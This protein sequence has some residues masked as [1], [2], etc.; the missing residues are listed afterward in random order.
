[1]GGRTGS[2]PSPVPYIFLP[3]LLSLLI[4]VPWGAPRCV[5]GCAPAVPPCPG[6]EGSVPNPKNERC[7]PWGTSLG[8]LL[9]LW[10]ALPIKRGAGR[11]GQAPGQPRGKRG[12]E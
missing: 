4:A 5:W 11:L 12:G 3:L 8:E 9:S 10:G 6:S 2:A 7:A 1:M